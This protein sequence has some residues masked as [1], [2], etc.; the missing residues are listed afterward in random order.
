MIKVANTQSLLQEAQKEHIVEFKVDQLAR[1][2][3][4]GFK[5]A[6]GQSHVPIV[7][8][9]T[10]RISSLEPIEIMPFMEFLTAHDTKVLEARLVHPSL[11]DVFVQ[12]TG[13]EGDRLKKEKEGKK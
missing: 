8:D 13:I 6:F 5:Q 11:E 2:T 1:E 10:I 3:A 12:I 9:H 4:Q 7:T